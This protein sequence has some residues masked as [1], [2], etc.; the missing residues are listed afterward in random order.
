MNA[1]ATLR[2]Q[3][4]LTEHFSYFQTGSLGPS[5]KCQV[6]LMR[7][8]Q[9]ALLNYG[10]A[11]LK[12]LLAWSEKAEET[13]KLFGEFL[14]TPTSSIAW[15]VNSSYAIRAV[16]ANRPWAEG[17]EILTSS[18]EHVGT[19]QLWHGM[20]HA[21]GVNIRIVPVTANDAEFLERLEASIT[22]RTRMIF[23]SHVSC[24]D[25]RRLPVAEAVQIA[26]RH[27]IISFID[28]AQAP[29]QIPVDLTAL[30][31]DYYIG[32][33]HK[34]MLGPT[35]LGYIV[36]GER[37]MESFNPLFAPLRE[38][39]DFGARF[40]TP[41]AA[42]RGESGTTDITARVGFA[43]TLK[44]LN[45]VG[46]EAIESHVRSLTQTFRSAL[47]EMPRINLVSDM[48]IEQSTGITSFSVKGWNTQQHHDLVERAHVE[49][50]A[51]LKYQPDFDGIRISFASFNSAEEVQDL[52]QLLNDFI[53]D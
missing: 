47:L 14:N 33:T 8:A 2:Q 3:I 12:V 5:P 4:Q 37:G 15:S 10:P 27:G 20:S 11:N 48:P 35:G 21:Y 53:V 26:K 40:A 49:R 17:D 44:L 19:R 51:I 41:T 36:V 38:T 7:E 42:M 28:G 45:S 9:D 39:A 29:A 23:L 46:I 25:G 13:R 31:A 30:D 34:W 50:K 22:P 16:F 1:L 43:E 18:L 32:S 52:I 6:E 24:I